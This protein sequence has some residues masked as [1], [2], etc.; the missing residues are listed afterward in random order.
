MVSLASELPPLELPLLLTGSLKML[1]K[2]LGSWM[3]EREGLG[4]GAYAEDRM[5][6]KVRKE[7]AELKICMLAVL[8]LVRREV[9]K[10]ILKEACCD[11]CGS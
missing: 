3:P 2:M 8:G 4:L 7:V 5:L 10:M 1:S 6:V 11:R 9:L